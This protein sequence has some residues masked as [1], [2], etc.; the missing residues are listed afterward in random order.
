MELTG[1]RL[2]VHLNRHC[3]M[4]ILSIFDFTLRHGNIRER[5][6]CDCT[7][8]VAGEHCFRV[9]DR[10]LCIMFLTQMVCSLNY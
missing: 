8:C 6:K 2:M 7:G 10:R 1:V 9:A 4:E 3:N 5:A